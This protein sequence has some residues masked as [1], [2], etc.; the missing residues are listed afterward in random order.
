MNVQF[1][2]ALK[3]VQKRRLEKE[4]TKSKNYMFH[5]LID[6]LK[7]QHRKGAKKIAVCLKI[8]SEKA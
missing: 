1:Q 7:N 4:S 6:Y 8:A 5:G 3:N 2:N